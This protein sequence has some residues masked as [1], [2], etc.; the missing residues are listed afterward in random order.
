MADLTVHRYDYAM[1]EGL[2]DFDVAN[3]V[4]GALEWIDGVVGPTDRVALSASGGVDSTT[5]GFLLKEVLGDRLH[6][7]FIDDG[8]RRLIGGREEWQ[9]T[10]EIF[11][12]FPNFE[13]IHTG[14]LIVP[15]FEGRRTGSP[16]ARYSPTS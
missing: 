8:L 15:W 4:E 7:F 10:A 16:T 5:V 6:P 12:D 13:V 9:V 2:A 1:P 14:E 11:S 3:Y